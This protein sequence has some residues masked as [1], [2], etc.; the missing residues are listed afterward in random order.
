MKKILSTFI[1]AA[2]ATMVYAQSAQVV[3]AWNYVK[4]G[5]YPSARKSIDE[6]IQDPKSQTW[7]KTWFYRATIYEASYSDT[8]QR[9]AT[10]NA[11]DE[12]VKSYYKALELDTK[13][14]YKDQILQGLQD[15]ALYSFNEGVEPYNNK[16]YI[17]AYTSFKRSSGIYDTINK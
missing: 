16:D 4:N 13:G 17:G 15:C 6:A 1:F 2:L 8:N 10:P 14:E 11:L 12:A 9:K 3:S 7:S 5:D